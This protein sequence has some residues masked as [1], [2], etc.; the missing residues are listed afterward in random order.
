MTGSCSIL[1][2]IFIKSGSLLMFFLDK[3][4]KRAVWGYFVY[5]VYCLMLC[6]IVINV[7]NTN[8]F[9]FSDLIMFYISLCKYITIYLF[10]SFYFEIWNK[11]NKKVFDSCCFL[12]Y[13][14]S[15]AHGMRLGSL[16][17]CLYVAVV[18]TSIH[19]EYYSNLSTC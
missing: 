12:T 9:S 18:N 10:I 13:H 17:V 14:Y 3:I 11:K 2:Y 6:K 16:S 15:S 5:T 7:Y 8:S 19:N 4:L 1:F